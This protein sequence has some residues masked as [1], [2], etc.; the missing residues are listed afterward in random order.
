MGITRATPGRGSLLF[1]GSDSVRFEHQGSVYEYVPAATGRMESG[2]ILA[3]PE[4]EL[5]ALR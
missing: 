1:H 2:A 3:A 5:F 4:E